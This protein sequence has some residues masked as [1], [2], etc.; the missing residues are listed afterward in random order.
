MNSYHRLVRAALILTI[1]VGSL[2]LS[3]PAVAGT[4]KFSPLEVADLYGRSQSL[5]ASAPCVATVLV[6]IT[7]DCPIS[8]TIAPELNRICSDYTNKNVAFL[9]IQ[10]DPSLSE[11]DARRHAQEFSL[12][13]PVILDRQHQ[14]VER[15]QARVTPE[16]F[17]ILADGTIAYRGRIDDLFAD[18]GKR[19]SAATTHELRDALDAVLRHQL[20]KTPETKAVGCFIPS[21]KSSER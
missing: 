1:C 2:A 10:V 14:L 4:N 21:L 7:H 6:F 15:A 19:R 17:V 9:L 5:P 11:K 16:A 13:A 20:V 8:N 18:L 3:K 12:T